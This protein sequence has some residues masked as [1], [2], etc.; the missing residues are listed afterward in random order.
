MAK[1]PDTELL[2][3]ECTNGWLRLVFNDQER[4]NAL[5]EEMA[6]A[7]S[8]ALAAAADDPE[9]RGIAL[10]GAQGVFCSGGDLKGMARHIFT[11]DREA[12]L[13]MSENGGRLF[14]QLAEQPQPVV[15]LID[16]PAL[17]GGLGLACCAD[18]IAVTEGAHFALTET[19]LG[20]PPAQIAPY[21]VAR[22]GLPQAKRLMLTGA[23]LTGAEAHR[24]GLADTLVA[25]SNEL[26]EF[27][28]TIRTQ[29]MR[30]APGATAVTKALARQ[31]ALGD[32]ADLLQ[33]AATAFTD[34]LLSDEGRE[35]LASFV[36][37]REPSWRSHE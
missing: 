19:Q 32:P 1:Y 16:G 4:R 23:K 6:S 33:A 18:I 35:G 12:I 13:A 11:G 34:C 20:I 31:A 5:S 3:I 21:V 10:T 25:D 17:A 26:I 22:L 9:V 14:A 36:E 8:A 27:E 37:K 7:L 2:S 29:I 30:C 24:I 15:A 28:D